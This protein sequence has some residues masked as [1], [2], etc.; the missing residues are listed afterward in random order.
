[1]GFSMEEYWSGLPFPTPGYLPNPGI[2]PASLE[3]PTFSGGYF[4]TEPPGAST[5]SLIAS[6][7]HFDELWT[8]VQPLS[9][10]KLLIMDLQPL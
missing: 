1:M 9:K 4:T 5:T 2:E 3:S 10:S 6:P 8:N 7:N